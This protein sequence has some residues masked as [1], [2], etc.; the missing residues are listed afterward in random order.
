MT[1]ERK[2]FNERYNKLPPIVKQAIDAVETADLIQTIS[3]AHKLHID[4]MGEFSNQIGLVMLGV[5][6]PQ[7]FIPN[8][9]EKL[10]IG[11][12]EARKIALEVNEQIFNPIRE[13]LKQVHAM[14]EVAKEGED[15]AGPSDGAPKELTK[16][17]ADAETK[18][19]TSSQ[20]ETKSS[21][22]DDR[23]GRY[24]SS[25]KNEATSSA[26]RSYS[27]DPYHEGIE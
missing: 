22:F 25:S 6:K 18:P 11:D 4:Q 1:E 23:L 26:P 5:V 19:V 20:L 17:E 24:L 16:K 14:G 7:E 3:E 12:E 27:H 8:L 2:Q 21:N 10:K 13:S 15:K 9:R